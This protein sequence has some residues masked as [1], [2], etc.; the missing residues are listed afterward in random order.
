MYNFLEPI[1]H[2]PS[3]QAQIKKVHQQCATCSAT[4]PQGRLRHPGPTHQLRGHQ[5]GEDWQL[6]FTHMP[7]HKKFRYLL[8]LADTFSGWI[9]AFPTTRETAEVAATIL[10]EHI[11]PRFGLPIQSDNGPAL[12]SKLTQQVAAALQITWKLHIPYHPQSSGKVD[13]PISLVPSLTPYS[14]AE[15]SCLLSLA[16]PRQARAVFLPLIIG[17]SLAASLMAS[18]LGTGALTHSVRSS[19]DLTARLQV[20]IKASAESL[21]SLQ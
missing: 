6:D 15:L 12:I 3:L 13:V 19:Q 17:V 18:G 7:R 16:L 20:A 9:E 14:E 2:L 4:N 10:L 5:P 1:F 21:A 8:T 11:V